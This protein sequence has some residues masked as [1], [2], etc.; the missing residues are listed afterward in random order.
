MKERYYTTRFENM[1][2]RIKYLIK[3]QTLWGGDE[4]AVAIA[5]CEE[6]DKFAEEMDD[7]EDRIRKLEEKV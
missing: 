3:H 4:V 2:N 5:V 6:F 1:K 7:L